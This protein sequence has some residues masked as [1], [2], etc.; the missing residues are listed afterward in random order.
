MSRG[1]L[2]WRFSVNMTSGMARMHF[3][4]LIIRDQSLMIPDRGLEDI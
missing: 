4:L 2:P 1:M 3:V